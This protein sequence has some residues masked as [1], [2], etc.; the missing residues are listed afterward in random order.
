MATSE[1]DPNK[2]SPDDDSEEYREILNL[3]GV[4]TV[5]VETARNAKKSIANVK[6]H[7]GSDNTPEQRRQFT[8]EVTD[9]GEHANIVFDAIEHNLGLEKLDS[10]EP[11]PQ[12]E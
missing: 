2:K 7:V 10:L 1:M 8:Q 5:L 11:T 3:I 12:D 6:N 4:R 9:V